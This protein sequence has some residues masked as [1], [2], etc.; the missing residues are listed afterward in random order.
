MHSIQWSHLGIRNIESTPALQMHGN[1]NAPN[2]LQFWM[3]RPWWRPPPKDLTK[4][5][6]PRSFGDPQ[7]K[8]VIGEPKQQNIEVGLGWV[9]QMDCPMDETG[10]FTPLAMIGK[11]HVS[12]SSLYEMKDHDKVTKITSYHQATILWRQQQ[13]FRCVLSVVYDFLGA[14]VNSNLTLYFGWLRYVWWMVSGDRIMLLGQS[15]IGRFKPYV[16]CPNGRGSR[17]WRGS[18]TTQLGASNAWNLR[19]WTKKNMNRFSDSV[20]FRKAERQDSAYPCTG[21]EG[22]LCKIF[23]LVEDSWQLENVCFVQHVMFWEPFQLRPADFGM[24]SGGFYW[25][26]RQRAGLFFSGDIQD[27]IR[28]T[29]CRAIQLF[30]R[31]GWTNSPTS[32]KTWP[33][34]K[35]HSIFQQ[36]LQASISSS[37]QPFLQFQWHWWHFMVPSR[38]LVRPSA[39]WQKCQ[40][41]LPRHCVGT[42]GSVCETSV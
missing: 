22:I 14:E 37:L 15:P 19:L 7:P 6:L 31:E 17:V 2:D 29:G 26:Q 34:C 20:F 33:R 11:S 4:W 13:W 9:S 8:G 40:D 28:V 3:Q 5:D 36:E 18:F 25:W 39:E 1:H 10:D 24:L 32:R 38:L 35:C 21:L 23:I 27:D 42:L 41:F 30:K 12:F 16:G